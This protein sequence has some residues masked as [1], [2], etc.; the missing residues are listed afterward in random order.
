MLFRSSITGNTT[1]SSDSS[2]SITV[3]NFDS[4]SA[5]TATTTDGSASIDFIT[6]E[7]TY[8]SPLTAPS[9]IN[10]TLTITKNGSIQIPITVQQDPDIR[11]SYYDNNTNSYVA[12][13][14]GDTI[15]MAE[16]EGVGVRIN[17]Y[18][19][20]YTYS[21]SSSIGTLSFSQSNDIITVS[22]PESN[23]SV[24]NGTVTISRPSSS[25]TFNIEVDNFNKG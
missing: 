7:I 2:V 12:I 25:Y 9:Q 15:T 24:L 6:G 18:N 8:S 10:D 1:L 11:L 19:P 16:P 14:S 17:N 3:T 20:N 23:D 4:F 5:Y 21:F 22:A 13:E